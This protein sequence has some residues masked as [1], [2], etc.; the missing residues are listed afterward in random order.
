MAPEPDRHEHQLDELRTEIAQLRDLF[1]RRLLDDKAKNRLYEELHEQ[2]LVARGALSEQ[3]LAP[4][5]R[6]LLLVVDRVTETAGSLSTGD[7]DNTTLRTVS[8]EL[9]E[10][11]GRRGVRR[12]PARE[13]FDPALQESVAL[14]PRPD[15]QPGTVVK[16]LR[17]G[18]LLNDRVL[19]AES[20][21][22]AT[23]AEGTHDPS[24]RNTNAWEDGTTS[25]E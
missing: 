20:V 18:Y 4:L 16:V 8:D 11:L 1:L 9:L 5:F 13:F 19:R 2:L 15:V 14:E 23:S 7:E 21:V 10:I 24:A 6:E 25:A 12:T 22:V 17:R 3:L